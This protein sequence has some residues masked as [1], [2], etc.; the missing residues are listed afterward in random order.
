M[1]IQFELEKLGQRNGGNC[2]IYQVFRR[3]SPFFAGLRR[4]VVMARN[5][6][7]S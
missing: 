4:H 3:F 1:E 6:I 5:E 2:M 7:H